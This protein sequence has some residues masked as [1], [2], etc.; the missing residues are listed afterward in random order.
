ML[1]YGTNRERSSSSKRGSVGRPVAC[2]PPA[3]RIARP[4]RIG[5]SR[6]STTPGRQ[7]QISQRSHEMPKRKSLAARTFIQLVTDPRCE[8]DTAASVKGACDE[9]PSREPTAES[10]TTRASVT[11]PQPPEPRTPVEG[12]AQRF[13]RCSPR[14]SNRPRSTV[15]VT[16]V[17]RCS[18]PTSLQRGSTGNSPSSGTRSMR[19]SPVNPGKALRSMPS[20]SSRRQRC[21]C[22]G[23][24]EVALSSHHRLRPNPRFADTQAVSGGRDVG[25][26]TALLPRRWASAGA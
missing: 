13:A 6:T 16:A 20:R 11:S 1:G 10:W 14:P 7:V 4:E 24:L 19:V 8:W 17:D 15:I 5:R 18:T 12:H 25:P 2:N 22:L 23:G 3:M 26:R 9:R 21:L